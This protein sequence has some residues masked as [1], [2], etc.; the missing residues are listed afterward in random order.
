MAQLQ[1]ADGRQ[2]VKAGVLLQLLARARISSSDTIDR[3]AAGGEGDGVAA[4][5]RR[6]NRH[7]PVEGSLEPLDAAW[8]AP[9]AT[10]QVDAADAVVAKPGAAGLIEGLGVETP[11]LASGSKPSTRIR[12]KRRSPPSM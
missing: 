6:K 9:V 7:A 11:A 5:A 2:Q 8:K 3:I 1:P 10:E 4:V 12:S